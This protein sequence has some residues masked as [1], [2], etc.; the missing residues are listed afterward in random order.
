[1]GTYQSRPIISIPLYPPAPESITFKYTYPSGLTRSI[2][3][4][5]Q[6]VYDW[7]A[8][9]SGGWLEA[10]VQLPILNLPDFA[11]WVEFIQALHGPANVFQFTAAFVAA[12][13]FLLQGGSPLASLYW[14]L[15]ETTNQYTLT[16]QRKGGLQFSVLQVP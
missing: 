6:Q 10:D 8:G 2:F 3:T 13:P 11:D 15:K 14:A 16:H 5:Q 12:Y 7:G 9:L 1:M 4:G